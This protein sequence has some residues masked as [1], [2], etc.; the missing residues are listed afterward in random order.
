[1]VWFR[2]DL[3]LR[4]QGA[5]AAAGQ[6]QILP[7]FVLD[8][9]LLRAV[10]AR[11][12]GRLAASLAALDAS[13]RNAGAD[14]LVVRTGAPDEVV[15]EAAR[16]VSARSVL[17]SAD[18]SPFGR[19][20]DR[21]VAA[22]L[23]GAGIGFEAAD[24]PYL[25]APGDVLTGAGS[26]YSVFTPYYRS[27]AQRPVPDP[28]AAPP[29]T[30]VRGVAGEELPRSQQAVPAGEERAA[31]LL[32]R[33]VATGLAA[34]RDDRN[35][36]DLDGTSRL[37]AA[38]HFGE[39][40][41]R[42]ILARAGGEAGA[43]FVRQLAWRDFYADVLFHNPAAGTT[44]VDRRFDAVPWV[45]GG[46]ADRLFGHWSS[47]RTGYPFVD[48]G[49]RQ[50]AETGWLHNRVRMV[51]ASFLTK[52]LLIDWRRG[53]DWFMQ[54]LL[55]ADV[56]NNALGWQWTAGT[57]TDAAPYFRVFNPVLQ[58]LKFDPDGD[59]VRRYIPELRHLP[60]A[61]V[62]EPWRLPD[63]YAHGYVPRLVDH[64]EARAEALRIYD[65]VKA[66]SR[67]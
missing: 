24:T 37:S 22:A 62:H 33:F 9:R 58:G 19:R 56:A 27:W 55:D 42:T 18:F 60:G 34:Y 15:T 45:Q 46:D 67:S 8:P 21:G 5:L 1:M 11:R 10:G 16:S 40:H 66:A 23:A 4:D 30:F 50:L 32:D 52:D 64:G 51:V 49:M 26:G 29:P 44:N 47:G 41:P 38:L 25:H 20:R 61:A 54:N 2:R 36:P 7:L 43:A 63:G 53:A 13:L 3:R 14:G 28:V 6:D 17:Y 59:Y 39:L 31:D 65:L 35:R 48:A 12:R 57:G